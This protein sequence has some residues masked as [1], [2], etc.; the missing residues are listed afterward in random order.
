MIMEAQFKARPKISSLVGGELDARR[1]GASLQIDLKENAPRMILKTPPPVRAWK[2][3]D[4]AHAKFIEKGSLK[5]G[6]LQD[7]ALLENGRADALDGG[8]SITSTTLDIRNPVHHRAMRVLGINGP[9]DADV[10]L[11]GNW[12]RHFINN[13]YAFCTSE[14]G[15]RH[16]PSPGTPKATYQIEDLFV[17]GWYLRAKYRDRFSAFNVRPIDYQTRTIDVL[18]ALD[19]PSAQPSEFVKDACFA[20]EQEIRLC[21]L[22]RRGSPHQTIITEPDYFVASLFRR[23]A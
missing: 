15:C 8:V 3:V 20:R 17:L 21:F 13:M 9:A 19:N 2:Q 1:L 11:E 12:T 7:Y 4:E 22:A 18:D 6:T 5:I 10:R 16:D 14:V 23:V